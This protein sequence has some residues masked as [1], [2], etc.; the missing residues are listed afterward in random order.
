MQQG[1]NMAAVYLADYVGVMLLFLILLARGWE[2]PGRKK[3]SRILLILIIATIIDCA[4]HH[5]LDHDDTRNVASC[6][7]SFCSYSI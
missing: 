6:H 7:K 4:T 3:E 5:R 2:L 1:I